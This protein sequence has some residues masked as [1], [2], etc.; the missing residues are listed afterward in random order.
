MWMEC[1]ALHCWPCL[2]TLQSNFSRRA[3]RAPRALTQSFPRRSFRH[4]NVSICVMNCHD[5]DWFD[6]FHIGYHIGH[7]FDS[8][9]F[10][11]IYLTHIWHIV[12]RRVWPFWRLSSLCSVKDLET[13]LTDPTPSPSGGARAITSS[14]TNSTWFEMRRFPMWWRWWRWWPSM[15]WLWRFWRLSVKMMKAVALSSRT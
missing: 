14:G 1:Q 6:W 15:F 2:K 7:W 8:F 5:H 12:W 9:E 11:W 13:A 4:Q 10:I 3:P